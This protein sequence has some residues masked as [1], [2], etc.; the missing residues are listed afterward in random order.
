MKGGGFPVTDDIVVAAVQTPT[1][2]GDAARNVDVLV[3]QI[4]RCAA[5]RIDLVVFPDCGLTGYVAD[6][7]QD[8]TD[9][10]LPHDSEYLRVVADAA[11]RAGVI[12]VF[13]YL[14]RTP[15][16]DLYNTA[17]LAGPT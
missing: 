1:S 17:A 2:M 13:G 5:D 7:R 11:S 14:E 3:E 12:A 4:S 8:A 6:S 15:D 10:A 16:G 9:L